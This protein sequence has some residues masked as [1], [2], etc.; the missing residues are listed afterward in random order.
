MDV[1][2]GVRAVGKRGAHFK[3][4]VFGDGA[5][6]GSIERAVRDGHLDENVLLAGSRVDAANL[7]SGFDF[8]VLAS[9]QESF[10]NALMESIAR[11][12]PVVAT[13]V[14]AVPEL[15]RDGIDGTLVEPHH[16]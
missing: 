12:V 6:R 8:T 5:E 15:V 16:S 1:L 13:R 9:N 11:G 10:P 3:L 4:V 2:E 14:G 7:L